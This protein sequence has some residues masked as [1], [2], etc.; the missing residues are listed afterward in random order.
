MAWE[1]R[2]V[3]GAVGILHTGTVHMAWAIMLRK[4]ITPGNINYILVSGA[5]YDV[6]RN[7]IVERFLESDA[8]WL[9]FIDSDVLL[10]QD[11]LTYLL[12]VS[13]ERNLPVVAALYWRRTPPIHPCQ[14]IEN[15]G[16]DGY[17]PV[18]PYE[19][20]TCKQSIMNIFTAKEHREM[21]HRVV[22]KWDYGDIL[23]VDAV[24]MGA[25]LIKRW[26]FEKLKEKDSGKPFFYYTAGKYG[27]GSSED[28]YMCRRL[29]EIGVKP[30]V[31]TN[32]V[33]KHITHTY[34]DGFSG[35]ID[36]L[37]F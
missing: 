3:S 20:M 29:K 15:E 18:N 28:F 21:G 10:P 13:G 35:E 25:T 33:A 17:I 2:T 8:E 6:S 31:A 11:A 34:I 16:G 24:H 4:L 5:P 30:A 36:F 12:K 1:K 14:W 37:E 22:K 23:L 32:I 27:V 19:C 7:R 26:V 9:M